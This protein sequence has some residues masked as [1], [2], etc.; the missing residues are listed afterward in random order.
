MAAIRVVNAYP[1]RSIYLM[2]MHCDERLLRRLSSC[3]VRGLFEVESPGLDARVLGSAA[4][5]PIDST[6]LRAATKRQNV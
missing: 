2:V 1:Q 5:W 3:D 6:A 4:E